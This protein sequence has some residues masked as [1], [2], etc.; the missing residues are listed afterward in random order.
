VRL[1]LIFE[2][3]K[4]IFRISDQG[5]GIPSSDQVHLFNAFFRGSNVGTIPG[6]GLGLVIV[7]ETVDL[8]RGEIVVNS[9]VGVGTTFTVTLPLVE[10]VGV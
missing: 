3:S 9:E 1:E 10:A 5:I 6:V 7:K 2:E 8:H 4:V